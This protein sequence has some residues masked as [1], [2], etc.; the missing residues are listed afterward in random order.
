MGRRK[1]YPDII[2]E[3][4]ENLREEYLSLSAWWEEEKVRL[5]EAK[6]L[7]KLTKTDAKGGK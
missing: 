4:F 2:D 5:E 6:K 1:K 7:K 3:E